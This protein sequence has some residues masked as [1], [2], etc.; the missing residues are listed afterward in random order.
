M[1]VV[2]TGPLY[3]A[4][5]A[6]DAHHDACSK[7]FEDC[8][9]RLVVPV[10]VVI[11]TSFLIERHLGA[12]AEAAFLK[13]SCQPGSQLSISPRATLNAWP[14]SSRPTP[15][16]PSEASTPQ[17][18]R[19]PNGSGQP[20]CLASTADTSPSYAQTTQPL[21]P[22]YPDLSRRRLRPRILARCS[23]ARPC[24]RCR[25]GRHSRRQALNNCKVRRP[26]L[27]ESVE[28]NAISASRACRRPSHQARTRGGLK[29][30]SAW[31][32]NLQG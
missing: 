19:S 15:T 7:L 21:S 27:G 16:C 6:S 1:I 22:S 5:D 11:E 29:R 31:V 3:A 25:V 13:S 30:H 28:S 8:T 32:G 23:E 26:K 14:N 2:D 20:R 4:A 12:A 18:S 24:R 9:D 17:S 10:S